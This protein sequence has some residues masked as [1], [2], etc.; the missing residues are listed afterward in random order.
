MHVASP[1]KGGRRIRCV[2]I[3]A[4]WNV[5]KESDKDSQ[6]DGVEAQQRSSPCGARYRYPSNACHGAR[7][8]TF[9]TSSTSS[10]SS[11]ICTRCASRDLVGCL[12]TDSTLT[13]SLTLTL[14]TCR[15]REQCT[16]TALSTRPSY[17]NRTRV[18]SQSNPPE[19]L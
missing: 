8:Y 19:G 7:T 3:D 1:T 6:F 5:E 17:Q 11:T 12:D 13:W 2:M 10:T 16:P 9:A 15:L 18:Q 14:T 4:K